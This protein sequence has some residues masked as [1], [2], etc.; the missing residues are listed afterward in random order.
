MSRL[1]FAGALVLASLPLAPA[2]AQSSGYRYVDED[3]IT[4]TAPRVRNEGRSSSGAPIRT[5]ETDAR[6]YIG[7][8]NLRT[9]EGRRMMDMRVDA[10]AREACGFLDQHYGS[11]FDAASSPRDC[12][13]DA[14]NMAQMQVRDAVERSAMA[15]YRGE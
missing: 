2:I 12:R 7:D 8:L 14:V 1:I 5:V 11:P 15:E 13:Q 6:A 3:S 9:R 4:V 10:A